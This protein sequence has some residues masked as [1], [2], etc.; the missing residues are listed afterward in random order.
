M[1]YG[2]WA[3]AFSNSLLARARERQHLG[4][5][6]VWCAYTALTSEDFASGLFGA[7]STGNHSTFYAPVDLNHALPTLLDQVGAAPSGAG[8]T[9]L[10]G[11]TN[12]TTTFLSARAEACDDLEVHRARFFDGHEPDW[13]T[14]VD[15]QVP[16]LSFA[17][18]LGSAVAETKSHRTSAR[19]VVGVGLMGE[20]K[21][22]A[23]RQ[24]AA[25]LARSDEDV[26]VYWREPGVN[27]GPRWCSAC[28]SEMA[29]DTS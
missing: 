21:S 5:D 4:M 20:G 11:W 3:D 17:R 19:V 10:R 9:E 14:A 2:G 26:R 12:V 7:L 27:C 29:S 18:Q 1:G 24:C 16:R 23:I 8:E 6:L 15:E 25:D 28:L 13:V 22:L